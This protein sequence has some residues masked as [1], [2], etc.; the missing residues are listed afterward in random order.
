[1]ERSARSG[2]F[3]DQGLCVA[4]AVAFWLRRGELQLLLNVKALLRLSWVMTLLSGGG[5]E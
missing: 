3:E 4:V 1:M 2:D 5:L